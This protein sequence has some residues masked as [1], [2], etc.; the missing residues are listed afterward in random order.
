ML[1]YDLRKAG[2]LA[3][4]LLTEQQKKDMPAYYIKLFK[5]NL[6]NTYLLSGNYEDAKHKYY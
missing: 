6:A 2:L 3:K 1:S 5:F 4:A